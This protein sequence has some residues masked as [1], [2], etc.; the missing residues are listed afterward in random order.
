[1][2]LHVDQ[3]LEARLC[4]F[5]GGAIEAHGGPSHTLAAVIVAPRRILHEIGPVI[6]G[7]EPGPVQVEGCGLRR[8]TRAEPLQPR[9]SR[10]RP[11][12][13]GRGRP[14]RST[15]SR[16]MQSGQVSV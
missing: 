1:M 6:E 7:H 11:H 2:D 9:Q 8:V 14:K 15:S 13:P 3:V 10:I 5:V 12:L 4:E 16:A